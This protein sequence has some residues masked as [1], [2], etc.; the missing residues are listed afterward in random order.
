MNIKTLSALLILSC[1]VNS[2]SM[3]IPES[4]KKILEE[5]GLPLPGSGIKLVPRATMG[6][7]ADIL[8]RGKKDEKQ[9]SRL[10]YVVDKSPRAQELLTFKEHAAVQFNLYADNNREQST[11]LRQSINDLR[12][13]FDYKTIPDSLV[14]EKI[15]YSPQGG[16]HDNGWS[17]VVEFFQSLEGS[18][19]AYAE[20]NLSESHAAAELA[21]EDV[22]YSINNKP[23]LNTIRGTKSQ[24]FVYKMKWFDNEAFHELECANKEYTKDIAN[25]LIELANQI[26]LR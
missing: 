12:L 13:G 24:G 4:H 19:C 5:M 18:I 17:G 8:E 2:F 6:L 21:M 23:T 16:F 26:D 11:H 1:S 7:P 15:A 25:S 3:E 9:L 14:Y 20:S 10:G 22:K